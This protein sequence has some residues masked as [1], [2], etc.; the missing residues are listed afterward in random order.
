MNFDQ[1]NLIVKDIF[2]DIEIAQIYG[3]I[4]NTP[5]D[6][7]QVVEVF[8]H[9]AYHS[10]MPQNIVETITR[11][12]QSTTDIPIVLRELSF[13]RYAKFD[14]AP[15]IQLTPH[16]DQTFREPRL[17]FDIQLDSNRTWPLVVEGRS[18]TLQNNEALTFSGTHQVHWREKVEF[19]EDD[20]MDMVFAH[21]S[22]ADY[23]PEEHGKFD[24]ND[25]SNMAEHDKLMTDKR[26]YWEKIYNES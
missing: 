13:A 8:S 21:F 7:K 6:R 20:Y 25:L 17:T 4:N 22:A 19:L 3:H 26:E 9:Q 18:Y 10:W 15:K 5:E 11:A 1:P 16:T 24:V 23:V 12:A 14:D 2:T